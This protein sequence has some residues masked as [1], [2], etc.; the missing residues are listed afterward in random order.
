MKL[1]SWSILTNRPLH[2]K[3]PTSLMF[4]YGLKIGV[5][6]RVGWDPSTGSQDQPEWS[7]DDL[8]NTKQDQAYLLHRN[9]S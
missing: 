8:Q 4:A 3:M 2:I 6:R 1:A 5:L 9:L 7:Q